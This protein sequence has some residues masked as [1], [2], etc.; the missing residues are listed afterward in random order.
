MPR[1]SPSHR[2]PGVHLGMHARLGLLQ[3]VPTERTLR[4][5]LPPPACPCPFAHTE[6]NTRILGHPKHTRTSHGAPLTWS[7][8][9]I[10]TTAVAHITHV[11]TRLPF[12]GA[13]MPRGPATG[14]AP[15]SR[16]GSA[17][18]P[19]PW[20]LRE[21]GVRRSPQPQHLPPC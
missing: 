8:R 14:C 7:V 6:S 19:S 11:R 21:E 5:P 17:L 13:H 12:A 16:L 3:A 20:D 1:A 4:P 10:A 9:R 15:R 18:D 2:C